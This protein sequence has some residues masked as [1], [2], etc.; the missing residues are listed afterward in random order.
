VATCVP[1]VDAVFM[2]LTPVLPGPMWR[3]TDHPNLGCGYPVPVFKAIGVM[4]GSV[5]QHPDLFHRTREII[6]VLWLGELGDKVDASQ[7]LGVTP[8]TCIDRYVAMVEM[9]FNPCVVVVEV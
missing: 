6:P 7:H 2:R 5:F 3:R 8:R 4:R 1:L 9:R